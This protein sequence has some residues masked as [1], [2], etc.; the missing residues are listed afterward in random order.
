MLSD[1]ED[2]V[3]QSGKQF[4]LPGNQT[5]ANPLFAE[6]DE[7]S[8]TGIFRIEFSSPVFMIKPDV[9]KQKKRFDVQVVWKNSMYI[10][11]PKVAP[12][13]TWKVVNITESFIDVNIKFSEPLLISQGS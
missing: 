6:V 3:S 8:I 4:G 11:E 2:Y 9:L 5:Q 12:I 13:F 1:D 7:V 10:E